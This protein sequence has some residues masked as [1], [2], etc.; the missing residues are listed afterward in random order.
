MDATQNDEKEIGIY[1]YTD[2]INGLRY[3]KC[4]NLHEYWADTVSTSLYVTL[5][6]LEGFE[7]SGTLDYIWKIDEPRVFSA[8]YTM[9]RNP[10]GSLNASYSS[11]MRAPNIGWSMQVFQTYLCVE[12]CSSQRDITSALPIEHRKFPLIAASN[13]CG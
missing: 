10:S 9:Y 8:L 12:E 6:L 2:N 11:D 7:S 4:L 3:Q 5:A 1:S 13:A